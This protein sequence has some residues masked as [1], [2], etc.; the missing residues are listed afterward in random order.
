MAATAS[1]D[2]TGDIAVESRFAGVIGPQHSSSS[3]RKK[4]QNLQFDLG[5]HPALRIT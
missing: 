3:W 1:G 5:F 4:K 2:L